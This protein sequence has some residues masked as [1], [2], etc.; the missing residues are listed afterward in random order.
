MLILFEDLDVFTTCLPYEKSLQM[1]Y[2]HAQMHMA[3][4]KEKNVV[5]SVQIPPL[6]LRSPENV[7]VR[8]SEVEMQVLQSL[9]EEMI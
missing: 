6:T 3:H 4:R 8:K 5:F 2:K 7:R 9:D 1:T